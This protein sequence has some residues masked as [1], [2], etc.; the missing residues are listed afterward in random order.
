MFKAFIV[1]ILLVILGALAS[2]F[3]YIV[4]DHGKSDRAVK[5]LTVRIALSVALFALLMI[6][7][8]LGYIKPTGGPFQ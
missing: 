7:A 5:A 8:K 1:A 6:S 4:K 3:Y 2:G